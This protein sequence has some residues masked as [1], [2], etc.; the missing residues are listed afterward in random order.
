M[1]KPKKND[2]FKLGKRVI[3]NE[4]EALRS[5]SSQIVKSE[6]NEICFALENTKGNIIFNRQ[7]KLIKSPEEWRNWLYNFNSNV[8]EANTVSMTELGRFKKFL[9]ENS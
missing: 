3:D 5:V 8:D 4:I 1:K 9:F 6:F 2:F 7:L